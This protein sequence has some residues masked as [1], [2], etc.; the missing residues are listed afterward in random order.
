MTPDRLRAFLRTLELGTVSAAANELW[1]AQPAL[2]RRL[3]TLE[4]ETGLVLFLRQGGRLVPTHAARAFAP[5]ATAMLRAHDDGVATTALL[6]KGSLDRL[7]VSATPAT[8]RGMLA[9]F[10]AESGD[11]IPPLLTLERHHD[12]VEAELSRRADL[13]CVP[14]VPDPGLARLELPPVPVRAYVAA[15]H[16]LAARSSVSLAE[17]AEHRIVLPG[18]RS[19]SRAVLDTRCRAADVR[20]RSALECDDGPTIIALAAAGHGVGITTEQPQWGVR[21]LRLDDDGLTVPMWLAWRPDHFAAH[22]IARTAA[23][24]A[25]SRRSMRSRHDGGHG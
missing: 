14:A 25:D 4:E 23:L 8:V 15:D 11:T 13:A 5:V 12:E 20:L 21:P 1:V 24:L 6:R 18:R 2:S 17:L 9:L 7:V 19:V 16:P 22:E 10:V 3:Q